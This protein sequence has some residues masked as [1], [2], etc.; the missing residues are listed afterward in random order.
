MTQYIVSM[1]RIFIVSTLL[2]VFSGCDSVVTNVAEKETTT[3]LEV[4]LPGTRTVIGEKDGDTYPIYWSE[5]DKIA[6]NG[7]PSERVAIDAD[8]RSRAIFEFKSS[9]T[10][11]FSITYPYS[12]AT[13]AAVPIVE[14][15]SEQS[16]KEGTFAEGSAPMCGYATGYSSKIVLKHLAGVL[17][18]SVKASKEGVALQKVVVTSTSGAKLSGEFTVDCT[19]ASVTPTEYT[20][21]TLTYLLPDNYEL[22]VTEDVEFYISVPP[23]EIGDCT[24]ELV[25]S[26]G[27]R[28]RC[29]WNPSSAIKSGVVREFKPL[30]YVRNQV[31]TLEG[32]GLPVFD[33]VVESNVFKIRAM[34]YNVHNAKGTDDVV[35]YERI[36]KAIADLNVDIASIQEVDS[37]TTRRPGQDVLKNIA[38]HA[39][40]YATFGAA[41]DRSGGKYG[42]G[43]ISK[44]KPISHYRVP[45]PCSSEP[46]VMLVAEFE[47]YYFCATHFSLLAEYRTQAV[48]IIIEEAKKLNKPMIVAGDLNALRNSEQMQLMAQHFDLFRKR[49]PIETFPSDEPIKEIDYICLYTDKGAIATIVDSWVPELTTFSDHRPTVVDAII[50]E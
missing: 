41:I 40:M 25:E 20:Q 26:S 12:V 2:L 24:I 29:E 45:L 22:P 28:M 11:P 5:G 8:D 32:V 18:L 19:T 43:I 30:T 34:S 17:K 23:V 21:N 14:F 39:G 36:G 38:D 7:V 9:L 15:Q 1:L 3:K 10:Y 31:V 50:C 27:D 37:M 4:G 16:Y 6:V 46:R 49:P 35:D 33:D 47:D 42:V 44:E 48:E 13:T